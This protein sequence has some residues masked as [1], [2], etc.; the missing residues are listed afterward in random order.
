MWAYIVRRLIYLIPMVLLISIVAFIVIEL[1]PGDIFTNEELQL[2]RNGNPNAARIVEARREIYGL[3]EPVISRYFI[4]MGRIVFDWDFGIS[5]LSQRE[6]TEIL[7]ER[8]P[9][10]LLITALSIIFTWVV[11]IPIGIYSAV[12]KYTV[13][14]YST[15]FV[16]FLG[17]AIPNFLLA[18]ILMLFAF[19]TLGWGIG[20]LMSQEF[21]GQPMSMAKFL[22]MAQH[23][24]IPVIVVAMSSMAGLVR[25]LRGMVLDE[26]GKLYVLTARAKGMPER[27]VI[28]KHILKI[29]MIPVISTIGW[30][31]PALISGET[32]TAIVMNLPTIGQVFLRS[33][34]AQDSYVSGALIL[35]LSTLTIIGSLISDI[36][37]AVVDK[38][39]V[40]S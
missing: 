40:Y 23:L 22:D 21:I 25:V 15:T 5:V 6:V 1:P 2:R 14:D 7:R 24:V 13:F 36:L 38:R 3:N 20:G 32:I 31:L 16:A 39:V 34:Q 30:I 10:T 12:K 35:I 9:T 37:L 26:M 19:N 27:V 18:L 17:M 33:L 4:W 11:A 28:W 29:A 8:L